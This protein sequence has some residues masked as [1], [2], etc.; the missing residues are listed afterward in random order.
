[1]EVKSYRLAI[2]YLQAERYEESAIILE[3]IVKDYPLCT[4][5]SWVLGLLYVLS[6]SPY[7]AL[8]QWENLKT[9]NLLSY[10]QMVE[11]KLPLYD[12]LY[13]KYN[14]A[15][16]FVQAGELHLAKNILHGLLPFQTELPLPVDFYHGY[17]LSLIVIGETE[18]VL[19]ELNQFPLYVKNS[20]V[21]RNLEKMLEDHPISE[22]V[23]KRKMSFKKSWSKRQ[24]IGSSLVASLLI[25][26][27]GFRVFSQ[28][29]EINEAKPVI[30]QNGSVQ[31][32][33]TIEKEIAVSKDQQS[34]GQDKK[35]VLN[36]PKSLVDRIKSST[37]S[38]LSSYRNGLAAFRKKDYKMAAAQ[39]EKSQSLQ[40][41]EY[42]SDDA[43]FFLIESKQR[44]N[45]QENILFLY[46]SFLSQTSKHYVFSPYRDE[47]LLGKA[48]I[49]ME[50]GRSN[51]ALPLLGKILT[52]F[53]QEWTS[54]EAVL[55][56]NQI[57]A[58]EKN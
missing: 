16:H 23:G 18:S 56:M 27:V 31:N 12:E 15:L 41:N 21:I 14:Q 17:L 2:Q 40:P 51:E 37:I 34:G 25:G 3:S 39:M 58:Q 35:Q 4:E 26:G 32:I 38:G 42:F 49:L 29:K 7:Q 22:P 44:L 19:Q 46:D 53:K 20:S 30:Q 24:F 11:E 8:K 5:A 57:K 43:L 48:K 10:K 1:M 28:Q 33:E 50:A 54:V 36:Y 13:Q 52:D 9:D 55:L 47:L 45:E 6:G